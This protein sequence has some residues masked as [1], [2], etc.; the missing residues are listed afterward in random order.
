MRTVVGFPFEEMATLRRDVAKL[1]ERWDDI[2]IADMKM[3]R[4]AVAL[5]HLPAP[6]LRDLATAT[7]LIGALADRFDSYH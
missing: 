5:V 2:S 4:L 6:T 3:L 1:N 7:G